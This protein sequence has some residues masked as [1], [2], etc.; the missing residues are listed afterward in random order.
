MDMSGIEP[1]P[2]LTL[3]E[4]Q[5]LSDANRGEYLAFRRMLDSDGWRQFIKFVEQ[6]QQTIISQQL[7]AKDWDIVNR[8]RGSF[9]AFEVIRTFENACSNVYRELARPAEESSEID[10]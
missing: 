10:A 8:C 4:V 7:T 5:Q 6:Q 1:L 2:E 9:A 3:D